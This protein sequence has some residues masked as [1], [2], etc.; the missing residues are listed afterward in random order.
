MFTINI[1]EATLE[2]VKHRVDHMLQSIDHLKSVD[3]GHELAAW[4]VEDMHR[5]RPFVM[6][7]RRAGRAVTIIRP[8]SLFEMTRS[9][10]YQRTRGRRLA[11]LLGRRTKR[12]W[13]K[14]QAAFHSFQAP[15]SQRDILRQE[16]LER[17]SER[18]MEM[19]TEKIKW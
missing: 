10:R 18:L 13:L 2:A 1:D 5:H 8:H 6:R 7:Y 12:S 11:R 17:L 9:K 14:A 15:T 19:A 4:Q 16:M 3:I